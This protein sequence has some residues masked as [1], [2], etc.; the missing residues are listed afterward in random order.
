MVYAN[1]VD[2]SMLEKFFL[3]SAS[4]GVLMFLWVFAL[5]IKVLAVGPRVRVT[6]V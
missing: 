4:S 2:L 3:I 5:V 6:I 1:Y